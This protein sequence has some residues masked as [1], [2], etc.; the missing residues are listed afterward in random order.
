MPEQNKAVSRKVF[1]EA[2]SKKN[3]ALLDQLFTPNIV[4]HGPGMEMMGMYFNAFPD[5]RMTVE[6][7]IAEGDVVATARLACAGQAV[8]SH[9][10]YA[11]LTRRDRR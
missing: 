4:Y 6:A 10:D 7:Q 1:E 9:V 8:T 5:L 11:L 3:L 2:A